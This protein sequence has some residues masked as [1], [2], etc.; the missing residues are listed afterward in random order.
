MIFHIIGKL[1]FE[2]GIHIN[3]LVSTFV[4]WKHR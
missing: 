1:A 3:R 4:C 2:K